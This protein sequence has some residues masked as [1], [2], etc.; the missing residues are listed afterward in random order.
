ME[1][2]LWYRSAHVRRWI[3][4]KTANGTSATGKAPRVC[5]STA[6][7]TRA[8]GEDLFKKVKN[9]VMTDCRLQIK[10]QKRRKTLNLARCKYTYPSH[11]SSS[12]LSGISSRSNT[13][14]SCGSGQSHALR[15]VACCGAQARVAD[16]STRTR[17]RSPTKPNWQVQQI[18]SRSL[19]R[20]REIKFAS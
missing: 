16:A 12:S 7:Q 20:P 19:K 15:N 10:P 14:S 13:P 5:S 6:T 11:D 18:K 17:R 1:L 3:A 8:G 2:L 4:N 9:S